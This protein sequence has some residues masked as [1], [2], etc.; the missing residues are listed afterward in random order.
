M[1]LIGRKSSHK[2]WFTSLLILNRTIG[3]YEGVRVEQAWSNA[4]A[5][6]IDEYQESVVRN[7]VQ[8]QQHTGSFKY[9]SKN[10][11]ITQP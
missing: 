1:G 11:F 9:N 4:D 8:K 7:V 6:M 2:D 10:I 5:P 3:T